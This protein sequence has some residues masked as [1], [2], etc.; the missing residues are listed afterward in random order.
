MDIN[1]LPRTA[2]NREGG[3]YKPLDRANGHLRGFQRP[4][5]RNAVS[6]K[7]SI[8]DRVSYSINK[9][10][11][12]DNSLN[13][14]TKVHISNSRVSSFSP[15][16]PQLGT[17]ETANRFPSLPQSQSSDIQKPN[18]ESYT[19][20]QPSAHYE[21]IQRKTTHQNDRPTSTLAEIS[22]INNDLTGIVAI[23]NSASKLAFLYALGVVVVFVIA[24]LGSVYLISNRSSIIAA[25]KKEQVAGVLTTDLTYV[26]NRV[27]N[28]IPVP[29]N[30]KPSIS[31]VQDESKV[32]Q[33]NPDFFKD[34]KKG[35]YFLLYS[36]KAILYRSSED[37]VLAVANVSTN[38][39]TQKST[40]K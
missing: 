28:L 10:D 30:E 38:E 25:T 20:Y 7:Q 12:L 22:S 29:A 40:R 26:E 13:E 5:E 3:K 9:K 15:K 35:D 36:T 17:S 24:G 21:T 33:Q 27:A 39:S 1:K 2:L 6:T 8:G 16:G 11:R 14:S 23:N 31:L 32:K 18:V 34:V 19:Q 4:V 37:K